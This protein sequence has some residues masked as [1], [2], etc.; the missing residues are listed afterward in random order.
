[1]TLSSLSTAKSHEGDTVTLTCSGCA[2]TAAADALGQA[3]DGIHHDA[4]AGSARSVVADLRG[5][6]FASSSCLKQFVTWL[7]RVQLLEAER[8]YKIVFRANP[9]HSWQRR[10]LGALA[11]YAAGCVEISEAS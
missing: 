1:V 9:A 10:S 6:E 8:R 11:D 7:K 2:E 4:M 3:L 5:L